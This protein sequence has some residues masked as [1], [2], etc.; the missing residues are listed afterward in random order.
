[1]TRR[2]PRSTRTDTL[3]PYTTL[4]RSSDN[5]F[6]QNDIGIAVAMNEQFALKAG[7]QARYNSE[8]EPGTTKTDTLTP[9]NLVYK[10][11]RRG[12]CR[13]TTFPRPP[14]RRGARL[15]P[16]TGDRGPA[17]LR[18]GDTG[19]IQSTENRVKKA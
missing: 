6:L 2:P 4:F 7:L 8:V 17:H 13:L 16:P 12:D 14:Q 1:M 9:I 18:L 15:A 10:I 3:F 19:R 11:H 5:T